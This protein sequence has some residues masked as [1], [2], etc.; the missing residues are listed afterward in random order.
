M[1]CIL[2]RSVSNLIKLL[3]YVLVKHIKTNAIVGKKNICIFIID[4]SVFVTN[5]VTLQVLFFI[6]PDLAMFV[7]NTFEK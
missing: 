5:S 6:Q 4:I 7:I 1:P 3:E 2:R